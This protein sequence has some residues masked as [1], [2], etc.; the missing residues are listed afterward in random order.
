LA[1]RRYGLSKGETEFQVTEAAGAAVSSDGVEI[2]I[3][4]ATIGATQEGKMYALQAIEMIKNHIM[5]GNWP[6]A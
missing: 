1:T 2:T 4:L 3:D 6:P 5:K